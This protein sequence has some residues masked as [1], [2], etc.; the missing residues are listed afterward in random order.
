MASRASRARAKPPG[1]RLQALEKLQD[2]LRDFGIPSRLDIKRAPERAPAS[3]WSTVWA[4]IAHYTGMR[5]TYQ[6][7]SEALASISPD[8]PEAGRHADSIARALGGA[9]SL[10]R[11][12]V[13]YSGPSALGGRDRVRREWTI[14]EI[15]SWDVCTYRAA[16]ALDP[17]IDERAERYAD[18]DQIGSLAVGLTIWISDQQ[19]RDDDRV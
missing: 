11:I 13:T 14:G 19:A 18:P 3:K 10:A 12:S 1:D 6:E 4:T 2:V 9:R 5:A 7:L 8:H 15:S 17:E 16:T